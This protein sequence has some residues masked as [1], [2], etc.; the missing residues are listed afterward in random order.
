MRYITLALVMLAAAVTG[1]AQE[2]YFPRGVFSDDT[3]GDQLRANWYS[4]HLKALEEP[5][6]I[7]WAKNPSQESYRFIWLRTFHHPVIVRL[8]VRT[9]GVGVLTAKVANGAGGY[10]P[11]KLIENTTRPLTHEQTDT[12]LGQVSKVGFWKLPTSENSGTTGEDG[13]QWIIEGIKDGKYHVVDRWTPTEGG[14]RELGLSLALGLAEMKVPK[15]E[16]Y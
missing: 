2:S 4:K 7:E 1:P 8:D 12:F 6:L 14:V 9:D 5:S 10:E 13:S 11:G 16:L 3:R 15:D